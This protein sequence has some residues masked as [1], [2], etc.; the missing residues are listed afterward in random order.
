[1]YYI[2]FFFIINSNFFFSVQ[3]QKANLEEEKLSFSPDNGSSSNS[4][5]PTVVELFAKPH[6][7]TTISN[8]YAYIALTGGAKQSPPIQ[9]TGVHCPKKSLKRKRSPS[10]ERTNAERTKWEHY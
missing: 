8:L 5:T 3:L 4:S 6:P 7:K 9:T 2:T 1:L 10:R